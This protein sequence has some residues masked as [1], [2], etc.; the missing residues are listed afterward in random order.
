M[1]KKSACLIHLIGGKTQLVAGDS[2][3]VGVHKIDVVIL[4]PETAGSLG[5]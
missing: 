1:L 2:N 5:V 4:R 3:E